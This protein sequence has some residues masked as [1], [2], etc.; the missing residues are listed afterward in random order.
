MYSVTRN[1]VSTKEEEVNIYDEVNQTPNIALKP[2]TTRPVPSQTAFTT[3]QRA[4]PPKHYTVDS[5]HHYKLQVINTNPYDVEPQTTKS[6]KGSRKPMMPPRSASSA[7]REQVC[8]SSDGVYMALNPA[9]MGS[10][11]PSQDTQYMPLSDATR[12]GGVQDPEAPQ[13]VNCQTA[14]GNRRRPTETAKL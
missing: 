3:K 5:D 6:Q 9:T 13:Y 14:L 7:G 1:V 10:F 8:S 11:Q 2:S 4:Q 12:R